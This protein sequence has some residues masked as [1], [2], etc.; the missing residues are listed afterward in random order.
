MSPG[1]RFAIAVQ[2]LPAAERESLL[3]KSSKQLGRYAA[4]S[5]IPLLVVAALAA[6]TEIPLDWIVTGR[7]M[8]RKPPLIYVDPTAPRHPSNDDDIAI[9]KLAFRASAGRGTLAVDEAADYMRFPRAILDHVGVRPENARLMQASGE[10]MAPTINDGDLLLIDVSSKTIAEG[11]VYA[12]SIGEEA[13]VKRLRVIGR[14]VL[15]RADNQALY[16]GEETA[17]PD[18]PLRIYGRVKW[19]GRN[20]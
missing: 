1:E 11:K 9:Q 19:A 5:E 2:L 7:A 8:E 16:P 17:P 20:L 13:F 18:L 12:F 6:A 15:I 14:R 4:G 10:S 3:G